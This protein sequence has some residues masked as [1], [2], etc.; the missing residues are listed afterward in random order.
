MK[1]NH[2]EFPNSATKRLKQCYTPLGK[3]ISLNNSISIV[4]ELIYPVSS[5]QKQLSNMFKRPGFEELLWHWTRHSIIDNVLSDIYDSQIWKN[6]KE[7]SEQE[8]NNF[9][10]PDKADAHLRLMMNLD[11]F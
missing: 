9:F 3:K 1:C 7:S 4:P 10:R 2:V 6:L 5:I 11:W 8:S